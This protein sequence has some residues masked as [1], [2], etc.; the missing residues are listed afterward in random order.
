MRR[1]YFLVESSSGR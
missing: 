1:F